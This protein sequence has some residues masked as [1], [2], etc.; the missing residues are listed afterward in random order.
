MSDLGKIVNAQPA[1][2]IAAAMGERGLNPVRFRFQFEEGGVLRLAAGAAM[3][4]HKP[5]R[6]SARRFQAEILFDQSKRKID[7][8]SHAG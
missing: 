6:D 1:G 3:V 5:T 2:K 4:Q 7:A 8:G